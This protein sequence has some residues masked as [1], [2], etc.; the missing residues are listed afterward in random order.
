MKSGRVRGLHYYYYSKTTTNLQT[1]QIIYSEQMHVWWYDVRLAASRSSMSDLKACLSLVR[2]LT[3]AHTLIPPW[4]LAETSR[5]MVHTR[6]LL[7]VRFLS[8]HAFFF[9]LSQG[10]LHA[11]FARRCSGFLTAHQ[12]PDVYTIDCRSINSV[13]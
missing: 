7:P 12:I 8:A 2:P 5:C 4:S 13:G 11:S 6:C 1:C 3:S 9:V 10:K